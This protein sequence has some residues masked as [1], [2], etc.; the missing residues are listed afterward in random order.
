MMHR[1]A[2][3]G[4]VLAGLAVAAGAFAAH[5]LRGALDVAMLAVFRTGARYQFYHA[6]ALILTALLA[7]PLGP[8]RGLR[9]AAG[10]FATGIALFSGSLYALALT[11]IPRLGLIT[12]LGG[13]A[14]LLGWGAL[15][16]SL[17]T[18]RAD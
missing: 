9:L 4:A 16:V 11:G 13:L 12:P 5:G 8:R 3:L 7:G 2:A 1:T 14:F 17:W 18:A 6:L 10:L 15:A